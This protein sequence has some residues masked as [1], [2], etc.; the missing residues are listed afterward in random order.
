MFL[1]FFFLKHLHSFSPSIPKKLEKGKAGA[2]TLTKEDDF[3][4][5]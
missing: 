1:K 5:Y 4:Q 2:C 3:Y